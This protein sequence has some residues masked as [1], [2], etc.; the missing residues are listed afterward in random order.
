MSVYKTAWII[1]VQDLAKIKSKDFDT[2]ANDVMRRAKNF[3]QKVYRDT[4]KA[5]R[6]AQKIRNVK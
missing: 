3:E 1:A 5:I 4:E 6:K 2:V